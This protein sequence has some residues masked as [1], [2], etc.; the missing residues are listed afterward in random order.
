MSANSRSLS[1]P[2]QKLL[3]LFAGLPLPVLAAPMFL[4]S[5]P[6]LL[7]A[8]CQAGI[9]GSLP[10]PNARTVEQLDHWLAQIV[11]EREVAKSQGQAWA[12]WM[13]N[14]IVHST[15]DR[16]ESELELIKRYQPP[17]V[18]TALGS[19]KRVLEI[20]HG[21]GGVVIADVITPALARKAVDASVDGLVLVCNGA[22][23]HTGSYNPFAFVAEVRE[24]WTGRS[25]WPVLFR[26]GAT[27]MQR[28][29]W[30]A[31]SPWWAPVWSRL[32][33]AWPKTPTGTCW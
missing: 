32:T 13:L 30:V 6:Q 3:D 7:N 1:A 9:V 16:F 25:V 31:I 12:P 20:V 26:M 18:S 5:G 4:V 21:Y 10:A 11:V 15:Y 14:M 28:K 29:S 24:F 19:P 8:C 17:I 22:G 2:Q 23:G 33:R 27:S